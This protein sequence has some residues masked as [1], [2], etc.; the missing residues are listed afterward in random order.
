M[1]IKNNRDKVA[2]LAGVSSATVSRVYNNPDRVSPAKKAA[3]LEAA[4][5]LAYSPD[6]SASALRRKGTG[7]ITLASFEKK[8]RPWYWGDFPGAKWFF[9]D[10]LKGMLSVVDDSMFRLNLKTL[11]SP[12]DVSS[13]RWEQECDGVVFFDVDDEAE[14]AAAASLSVPAVISHHTSHFQGNH[15]CTTDN[16]EGGRLSAL[17]LKAQGFHSPHYITYLPELIVPNQ[18]RY[19]GFCSG[20]DRDIPQELTDPGKEGGYKAMK[21]LLPELKAG[22]MDSVAVV[23]DMTAVGVIQ[24]LQ[25]HGLRPGRDL[26]LLA[27]DNMPF[28]Y[29]F[30]FSL[31]TVDLK[32]YELYKRAGA[33]LLSLIAKESESEQIQVV[34]PELI[35]GDS[36]SKIL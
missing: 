10:V 7:Q 16:K 34:S 22:R 8:D 3:V 12:E 2:E 25:D 23:N 11:K 6:K 29:V 15:C 18:E 33:M 32:P 26:G 20:W 31:T 17:H 19:S 21:K 14:A 5:Q 24:C 13:I 27:Y 30:P 36:S 4:A 9:T 35:Q 28:N 1:K